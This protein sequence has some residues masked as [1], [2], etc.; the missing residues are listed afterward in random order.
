VKFHHKQI[1]DFELHSSS[2]VNSLI[3]SSI[4][5]GLHLLAATFQA[6]AFYVKICER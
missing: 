6:S 4:A 1:E 3:D 2:K 5:Y